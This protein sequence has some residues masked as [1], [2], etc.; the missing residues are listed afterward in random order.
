MHMNSAGCDKSMPSLACQRHPYLACSL[1]S[2]SL[3][4]K[5]IVLTMF[6]YISALRWMNGAL[7]ERIVIAA[8]VMMLLMVRCH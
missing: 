2:S 7:V 8:V 6:V 4:P 5:Q 3:N 1:H